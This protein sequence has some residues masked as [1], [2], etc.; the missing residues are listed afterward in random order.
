MADYDRTWTELGAL[1]QEDGDF[2]IDCRALPAPDL[3]EVESK[4]RSELRKRHLLCVEVHAA[5]S[6]RLQACRQL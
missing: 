4:R 1:R 6:S 3:S 5:V 2:Q